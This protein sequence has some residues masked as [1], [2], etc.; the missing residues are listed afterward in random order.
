VPL[1]AINALFFERTRV[2]D[3]AWE[4][5]MS[6]GDVIHVK[7]SLYLVLV[8]YLVL[9]GAVGIVYVWWRKPKDRPQSEL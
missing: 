6:E 3:I 5:Q 4:F 9:L 7:E 2:A 8:G 1:T